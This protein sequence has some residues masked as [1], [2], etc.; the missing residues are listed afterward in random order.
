MFL[1]LENYKKINK[2]L[3]IRSIHYGL[4]LSRGLKTQTDSEFSPE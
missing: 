2:R 4:R 3:E 1:A